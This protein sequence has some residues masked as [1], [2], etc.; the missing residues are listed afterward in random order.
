MMVNKAFANPRISNLIEGWKGKFIFSVSIPVRTKFYLFLM[1]LV[2]A[3][4]PATM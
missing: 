1:E 4:Q 3:N 2:Q